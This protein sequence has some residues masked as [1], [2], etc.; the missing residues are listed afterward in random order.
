MC[1]LKQSWI[2]F[3]KNILI[4][5]FHRLVRTQKCGT[6]HDFACHPCAGAMLIFSVSF[7]FQY[8]YSEEYI[9]R[10]HTKALYTLASLVSLKTFNL[11]CSM[12]LHSMLKFK[13]VIYFLQPPISL[14]SSFY[15]NCNKIIAKLY[16][17]RTS[18]KWA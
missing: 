15:E 4:N 17:Q 3:A 11:H 5:I 16:L 8:M 13:I 12:V 1:L 2:L 14:T 7:Q 10:T 18:Q 6:L 9:F